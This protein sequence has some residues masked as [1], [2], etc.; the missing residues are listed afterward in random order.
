MLSSP[1][2]VSVSSECLKTFSKDRHREGYFRTYYQKN[3]E[4]LLS[5]RK[6]YYSA[7]NSQI[8]S[9]CVKTK[10]PS[11]VEQ[12]NVE[13]SKDVLGVEQKCVK[14]KF[15]SHT[16]RTLTFTRDNK[17]LVFCWEG[18]SKKERLVRRLDQDYLR[19]ASKDKKALKKYSNQS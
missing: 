13:Q 7:K 12:F 17:E 16:R 6:A 8:W 15:L 3:R 5:K 4:Q 10:F 2:I 1:S 18:G 19:L 14:T 9:E 11:C